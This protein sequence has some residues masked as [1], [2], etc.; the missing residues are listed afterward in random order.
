MHPALAE[1]I[2]DITAFDPYF[3]PITW[4]KNNVEEIPYSPTPGAV[5]LAPW[6]HDV[7]RALTDQNT[8]SVSIVGAVQTGKTLA[9]ELALAYI[10]ANDPGPA[11]WLDL[12]D[13][14]ARDQS[15]TRLRALFDKIGVV[16]KLFNA[17]KNKMRLRTMFFKN[18]MTLWVAGQKNKRNL[19]RRSIRYIFGDETWLW[20]QGRMA[21][22]IARTSAYKGTSLVCFMSQ[23]GKAGDETDRFFK[24]GTCEE[25]HFRCPRC[26][27][28]FAPTLG[29]IRWTTTKTESGQRNFPLIEKSALCECPHCSTT[30]P[31]SDEMR[32]ELNKDGRFFMFNPGA[33]SGK[34]SFH[35]NAFCASSWGKLVVE[36]LKA[37][38]TA[39]SGD[40]ADLKA[41]YQ[42]RLAEPWQEGD[43]YDESLV[44]TS[45][46]EGNYTLREHWENGAY[47]HPASAK[48]VPARFYTDFV[49]DEL[50][51]LMF[52]S[53]DVQADYFFWVLRHWD[54]HGNSRLFDCGVCQ[55]FADI[56]AIAH[57]ARVFPR[58]VL[59]DCGFRTEIVLRTVAKNNWTALRGSPKTEWTLAGKVR[60]PVSSVERV[61]CGTGTFARRVFFSNL[62][63]KDILH[64]IRSGKTS[65]SWSIS[66]DAPKNYVKMLSSE[67]RNNEKNIW[68]RDAS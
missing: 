44:E 67:T 5:K 3:E 42:K 39:A 25:W 29:T 30:F 53:V 8:R 12:T 11:L 38:D 60:S 10:I 28:F 68:E 36:Y 64:A 6:Q 63:V 40:I 37:K 16:K 33:E 14:S 34:R 31:D 4:L 13:A 66:S 51:P 46:P 35:W 50:V 49:R 24:S 27:N 20:E 56:E 58:F 59:V 52:L 17:D 54:E 57:S 9:P 48:I 43:D 21:E 22:A 55:T 61:D 19:Q 15:E 18:K 2:E 23:A 41:F 62:R 47:F 32:A 45:V 7:F 65:V 26:G 1:I